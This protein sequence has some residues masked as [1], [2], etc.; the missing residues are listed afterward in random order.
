MSRGRDFARQALARWH[1]LAPRPGLVVDHL[2]GDALLVVSEL[3]ANACL[4]GYGPRELVLEH[5]LEYLCIAVADHSPTPPHHRTGERGRPDGLGL[6]VLDR[7]T[8]DWG[9]AP[10]DDGKIV[11]ALLGT[12]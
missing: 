3:L 10:D 4:H 9:V 2:A 7:L 11:W 6:L 5:R 12:H 8:T 1:L